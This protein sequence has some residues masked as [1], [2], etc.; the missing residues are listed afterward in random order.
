MPPVIDVAPVKL[1]A[2]VRVRVPVPERVR[3]AAPVMALE[4]ATL[5]DPS[6]TRLSVRVSVS[7]AAELRT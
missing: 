6:A 3:V 2:P 4:I 7:P 5:P 1:F